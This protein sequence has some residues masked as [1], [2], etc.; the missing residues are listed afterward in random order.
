MNETS[1]PSSDDAIAG[2]LHTAANQLDVRLPAGLVPTAV[3][4]GPA[5][6]RRR[7]RLTVAVPAGAAVLA[8][9][10]V[11]VGVLTSGPPEGR[12]TIRPAD[13]SPGV[14]R[15]SPPGRSSAP[16][17]TS[18]PVHPAAPAATPTE[19]PAAAGGP[20]VQLHYVD[21]PRLLALTAAQRGIVDSHCGTPYESQLPPDAPRQMVAVAGRWGLQVLI[22][23]AGGGGMCRAYSET[24]RRT[25]LPPTSPV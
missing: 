24:G 13:G 18:P 17:R 25:T 15:T 21:T 10:L 16:V 4:A 8:A 11:G 9:V 2:W 14:V 3:A 23:D 19:V 22:V 1:P 12:A 6:R 7:R 20:P 5:A